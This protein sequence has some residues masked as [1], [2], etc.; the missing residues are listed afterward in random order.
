M[1]H[2][3]DTFGGAASDRMLI[4]RSSLTAKLD[5]GDSLM[6]DKGFQVQDIFAPVDV[7]VNTPTFLKK[8]NQF[9]AKSL[10]RDRRI[11]S[12][13]VH[14]ERLIGLAKTY[15]ILSTPLNDIETA[16]GSR[17]LFRCFMLC[18]FRRCIVP[19]TA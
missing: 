15:K 17:I 14:V 9:T 13:R 4:E 18:N 5:P 6:T 12:K 8:R 19:A 2:I 11:A 16:L 7:T 10:K 3:P 1:S